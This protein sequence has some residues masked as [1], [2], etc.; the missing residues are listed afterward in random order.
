MTATELYKAGNLAEAIDTQL[1]EVKA[2]PA[3]SGRRLFLFE[4]L[5][6]SGDLDRAQRQIDAI[7]YSEPD[8]DIALLGYKK[9]LAAEKERRAFFQGGAAPQF[10]FEAPEHARLRLDAAKACRENR[11]AEAS[12]LLTQAA[13]AAPEVKGQL[14]GK[15]FTILRDADDL[16]GSVL[17]VLA[18]GKYFWVPLEQ[19]ASVT[20]NPPSFPRDLFWIPA[21]LE[22][23]A[24]TKG[25]VFLPTLY[26]GAH[27]H[28]DDQ[29]KLGHATD[30]KTLDGGAV[31]GI[32]QRTFLVG[33]DA[34]N[35]LEWRELVTEEPP[36]PPAA[37]SP[38]G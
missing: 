18:M 14:N 7:N 24:G 2:N 33:D 16:F 35:I 32:G 19:I 8:K 9:A 21:R 27:E 25:E 23:H 30:W 28:P 10:L 13:A 29:V 4:L 36:A 31:L 15:P 12:A 20:M 17:E 22:L 38:P 3:D 5:V 1:K 6:F 26:P 37:E 11:P 34:V